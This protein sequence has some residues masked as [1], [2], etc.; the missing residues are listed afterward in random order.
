[1][2]FEAFSIL[3]KLQRQPNIATTLV[4]SRL[5]AVVQVSRR[6]RALTASCLLALFASAQ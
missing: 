4:A 2:P 5:Q 3:F 6:Y 1:M